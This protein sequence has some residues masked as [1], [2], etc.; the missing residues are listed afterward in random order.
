MNR[1]SPRILLLYN[2]IGSFGVCFFCQLGQR[3]TIKQK[4]CHVCLVTTQMCMLCIRYAK[5][6]MERVSSLIVIPLKL[7][8]DPHVT[9]LVLTN[10]HRP[11]PT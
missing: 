10:L 2:L 5:A 3:L 4:R 8:N 9:P 6:L 11:R 1:C 7:I